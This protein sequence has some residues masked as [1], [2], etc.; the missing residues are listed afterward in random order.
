MS[1]R[2]PRKPRVPR[3]VARVIAAIEAIE[4]GDSELAH[5]ILLDLE[6]ELTRTA[7]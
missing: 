6:D 2:S 1:R 5:A 4:L 3:V 7:A